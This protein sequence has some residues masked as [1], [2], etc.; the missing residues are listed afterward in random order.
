MENNILLPDSLAFLLEELR[1]SG[2]PKSIAERPE[3]LSS[4][5]LGTEN[6]DSLTGTEN[7]DYIFGL[8]GS[9]TIEGLAGD[10]FLFSRAGDSTIS[11]GD[12]RDRIYARSGRDTL[13]GGAGDD[14]FRDVSGGNEIDGGEGRDTL[15]YRNVENAI[16][17]EF[18]VAEESTFGNVDSGLQIVQAGLEPDKVSNIERIIAPEGKA[19]FL[20]FQDNFP[21]QRFGP[22]PV[23]VPINV[24][25]AENSLRF[26]SNFASISREPITIENFVDVV[27]SL[28]DDTLIGNDAA[29]RLEGGAGRNRLEGGGGDDLLGVLEGDTLTGGSGSDTFRL[30]AASKGV[31]SFPGPFPP[32]IGDFQA[33]TI[34]DFQANLDKLQLSSMGQTID[35]LVSIGYGGFTE[36][37]LGE[38]DPDLFRLVGSDT[39]PGVAHIAY[40]VGTG[41]LFYTRSDAS[42]TKVATLQGSPS[43]N[44]SDIFVV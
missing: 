15:N 44:A 14:R 8:D 6:N 25:L 13:I 1:L 16:G 21:A 26:E 34:L 2:L 4:L 43:L 37:P 7:R 18:N 32:N 20:D 24:N 42:S 36:L 17:F 3:F 38:L 23:F 22:P 9:D 27:G 10:D 31:G 41:D 5:I 30:Q 35:G 28:G 39:T 40:D 29:N 11:G 19:N 12:G 33:N